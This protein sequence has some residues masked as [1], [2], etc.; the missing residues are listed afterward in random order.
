MRFSTPR[1]LL[2]LL[3]IFCLSFGQA[4]IQLNVLGTYDSGIFDDGAVEIAAFFA[5]TDQLFVT[6]SGANSLDVL[7]LSD[8]TMPVLLYS[9]DLTPYGGG[10]NSVAVNNRLI[11]VAV[12]ADNKQMPG[13]VVFFNR[14]GQY[15]NDLTVG[16]L[17]DMLTFTPNGRRLLVANEG[18]PD[19]DYIVD[20]VGSISIIKIKYPV[21]SMDQSDVKTASIGDYL[22]NNTLDPD[23]RVFGP[24]ATAEQDLEPEYIVVSDNS[25]RAWV[26]C[27]EN[28]AI[29]KVYIPTAKVRDIFS[30]GFKDHSLPGNALDASNRDGVINIQNWPI[31]GMY[32]PD[33]MAYFEHQ[34][35]PYIITANEGD[36]RDYDGFSEEDRVNDLTL[37]P[38][39]FPNA[40]D[41]QDNDSLGR[42]KITTTLGDTDGDGDYD[43]LY[44]YGARSFSIWDG[45]GN[46]IFDSGEEFEQLVAAFLPNDFNSTDDENGSFDNRS[47]DKGPEPEGVV[48]GMVDN[49]RYAFIGLERVGGIMVYDIQ[50]PT[51]PVF[52]QYINNRDFTG[53]AEMGTAGDLAP[54]GLVFIPS[55]K[56]PN[57]EA[58]LVVSNE[59]SGTVTAYGI[60]SASQNA[61][62]AE[63]VTGVNMGQNFPNPMV[64]KT[65]IPLS[66]DEAMPV[67]LR[68]YNLNG[69]MVRTLVDQPMKAGEHAIS[70]NATDDKGQVL[71]AGVYFYRL[72]AGHNLMVRRLI[73]NR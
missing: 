9:I 28:N 20:P 14:F 45:D 17:P 64:N 38:S 24:G 25:R 12:E 48:V 13:K 46:Q 70:W 50:D 39:A 35:N 47:D 19:D 32:Q 59:V 61:R 63:V 18:E 34:G 21:S 67:R 26:V 16:A 52:V 55:G 15:L 53:D 57:G 27:Q 43:E 31:Y 23:V 29:A 11:A 6:N 22:S 7:D 42:I 1:F 62:K 40:S 33:A 66:L 60:S 4:Q 41:L 69:Q 56:S 36:A 58:M 68:V 5:D 51:Q 54:E 3:T 2:S 73:I 8:P 71:P 65:T 44:A 10:P 49:R 72:E 37:D 30:L